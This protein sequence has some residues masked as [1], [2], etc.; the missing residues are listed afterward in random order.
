MNI[1][2]FALF[3][4][5]ILSFKSKRLQVKRQIEVV[6]VCYLYSLSA[7]NCPAHCLEFNSTMIIAMM[8]T[9]ETK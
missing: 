5:E 2:D 7:I 3:N 1:S 8:T 4:R 9:P 6:E